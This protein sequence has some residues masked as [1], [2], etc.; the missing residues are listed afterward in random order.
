MKFTNVAVVIAGLSSANAFTIPSAS[1]RQVT[2]QVD[3]TRPSRTCLSEVADKPVPSFPKKE[4]VKFFGATLGAVAIVLANPFGSESSAISFPSFSTPKVQA[5]ASSASPEEVI[6]VLKKEEAA[7]EEATKAEADADKMAKRA[8]DDA[9]IA[10]TLKGYAEREKVV[11]I[12]EEEAA[13][14]TGDTAKELAM[15]TEVV[16]AQQA[17]D[18]MEKQAKEDAILEAK[19]AEKAIE[20]EAQLSKVEAE[21][22]KVTGKPMAKVQLR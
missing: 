21:V 7:L 19:A 13:I 11:A 15:A 14:K 22:A 8:K 9:A 5:S 1:Q 3:A 2:V 4:A 12:F 10:K 16:E 18:M 20:A 17:A 6:D